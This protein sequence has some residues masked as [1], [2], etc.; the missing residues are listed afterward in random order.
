MAI[1]T[2][3]TQVNSIVTQAQTLGGS[4]L[5]IGPFRSQVGAFGAPSYAVQQTYV[6]A[7]SSIATARGCDFFDIASI[8]GFA[9]YEAA[10]ALGYTVGD[11]IHP[12][13][14]GFTQITNA[15]RARIGLWP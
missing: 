6:D 7:I 12:S 13:Y 10:D 5:L 8:A 2:F 15:I 1:P 11:G 14:A 4:C 9:T 3:T